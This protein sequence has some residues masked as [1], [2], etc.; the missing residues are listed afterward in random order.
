MNDKLKVKTVLKIFN[1]DNRYFTPVTLKRQIVNQRVKHSI[2]WTIS[3]KKTPG[4]F[5]SRGLARIFRDRCYSAVEADPIK[6]IF[7]IYK[8][9]RTEM[10]KELTPDERK[11]FNS[12]IQGLYSIKAQL[13]MLRRKFI[14][15]APQTFVSYIFIRVIV[16]NL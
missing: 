7:Q 6:S 8:D 12:E 11:S 5:T 1:F 9:I 16:Y 13:Y 4:I 14:P 3:T 10:G 15:K 2:F